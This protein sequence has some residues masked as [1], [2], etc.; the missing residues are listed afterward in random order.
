M[1]EPQGDQVPGLRCGGAEPSLLLCPEG[2]GG[3]TDRAPAP[4]LDLVRLLGLRWLSCKAF[5]MGSVLQVE[6]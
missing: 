1:R 3:G 2:G 6:K 4:C 5:F